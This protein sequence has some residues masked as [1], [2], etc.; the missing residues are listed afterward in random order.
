MKKKLLIILASVIIISVV[1]TSI[2]T[3]VLLQN[4]NPLNSRIRSLMKEGD[5]PSLSAGIIIE[6]TLVWSKGYGNQPDGLDTVYMIGSVTKMFTAT[7]IMQLYENNSLELDTD[8]NNYIP[9]SIRNPNYP[10]TPITIRDLLTHRSS[11]GKYEY[12]IW[13]Y[14]DTF[15]TWGNDNFGANYTLFDPHPT[16]G[17]FLNGSL[18]PAGPYYKSDHW[19]SFEPGANWQYSNFGFLLLAYIVEELTSQ[20]Y[21]T[22]LQDNVLDPLSMTSTGF[23]YTDFSGRNA[24]PY[25]KAD[26]QLV[27]GPLYNHYN[28]GGGALRSTVPDLAKFLIVHMNQGSYN[29]KEILQ[30]QTVALMQT[31][32]FSM[33][34]NGLGG[35]SYLGYG[36]GWP[37]YTDGIIAHGGAVPGY[38]AQIA[39]KTTSNGTYGILF[40]LNLGSSLVHDSYLLDTFFPDMIDILFDE[41]ARLNSQ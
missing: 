30:P 5:I 4:A 19:E 1:S 41:A 29:N 24:L 18:N 37:I 11:I 14:D 40:S 17:E 13:D 10:S 15:L 8:I 27:L 23:N 16:I 2:I 12:T 20:S 22:Y 39:F 21:A 35:L 28:V 9:F 36:L 3:V 34:G 32:Q 7:S 33:F 25:E 6:D 38:L 26:T 31:S